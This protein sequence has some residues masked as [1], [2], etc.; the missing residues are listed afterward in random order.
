MEISAM[1][2]HKNGCIYKFEYS[3]QIRNSFCGLCKCLFGR[4]RSRSF[5]MEL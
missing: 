5:Q 4:C 1:H 3:R 2:D